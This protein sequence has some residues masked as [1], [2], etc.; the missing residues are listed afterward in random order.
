MRLARAAPANDSNA[1]ARPA[2]ARLARPEQTP[3]RTHDRQSGSP[4]PPLPAS[5]PAVGNFN[6]TDYR[7][8]ALFTATGLPVGYMSGALSGAGIRRPAMVTGGIIGGLGGLMWAMQS[9]A[10]RLMGFLENDA[11]VK[12]QR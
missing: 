5:T 2:P 7:D 4:A 10:G 9:S 8:W 11:E 3:D 12:R 1:R 6:V